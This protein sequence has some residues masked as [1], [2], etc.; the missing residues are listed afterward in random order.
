MTLLDALH[1]ATYRAGHRAARLWWRLRRP[2]TAGTSVAVWAGGRLLVVRT[3]YRRRLDLPG[4][5]LRPGE[6]PRQG[7]ARELG[8]EVGIVVHPTL[9]EEQAAL[10]FT[11]DHRRIREILFVWRAETAPPLRVD[12]REIV[13]A[14]FVRPA[15]L[16]GRALSPA[17]RA[18]LK[19]APAA[20]T[21][22]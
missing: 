2:R 9:L 21:G 15:E 13:W 8:E 11:E 14:G 6:P 18:A 5:G 20:L 1:R 22:G 19:A 17:L 10:A 3:S 4:G 12:R 16:Q 7:A